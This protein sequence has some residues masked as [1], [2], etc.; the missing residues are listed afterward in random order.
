MNILLGEKLKSVRREK[1]ISQKKTLQFFTQMNV[2]TDTSFFCFAAA[3]TVYRES[4]AE[5][6]T[7]SLNFR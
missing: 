7:D 3:Y 6:I 2:H 4:S 1:N 5:T